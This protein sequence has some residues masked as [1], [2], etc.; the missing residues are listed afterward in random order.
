MASPDPYLIGNG[1]WCSGCF[2]KGPPR[3]FD[4]RK[5]IRKGCNECAGAGR[6]VFTAEEIVAAAVAGRSPA[7]LSRMESR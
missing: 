7:E 4:W 2:P 6:I 3:R 5:L 1:L